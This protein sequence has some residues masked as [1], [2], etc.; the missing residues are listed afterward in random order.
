MR[1]IINHC[2]LRKKKLVNLVSIHTYA[3]LIENE[4][5]FWSAIEEK[6]TYK[7]KLSMEKQEQ[8]YNQL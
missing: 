3:C 5:S 1:L 7:T 4:D 6:V 2:T 8:S